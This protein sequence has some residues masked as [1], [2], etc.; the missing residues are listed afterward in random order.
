MVTAAKLIV[1]L[2]VL[3]I[4]VTVGT[5]VVNSIENWDEN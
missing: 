4:L 2:V 5:V 3:M 1:C